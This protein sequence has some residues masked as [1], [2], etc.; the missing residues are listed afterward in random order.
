LR[1]IKVEEAVT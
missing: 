1:V